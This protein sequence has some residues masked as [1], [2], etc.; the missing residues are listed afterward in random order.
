M[1]VLERSSCDDH[2][3]ISGSATPNLS[4]THHDS[5][6]DMY[7]VLSDNIQ[8]KILSSVE[9]SPF[10]SIQIDE[11]TDFS[12][13]TTLMIYIRYLNESGHIDSKF[14]SVNELKGCTSDDIFSSLM[15]VVDNKKL[16]ISKLIGF[17]SDG[18]AVMTGAKKGVSTLIKG[19]NPLTLSIHCLAH[20]LPLASEK[21]CK[22]IPYM[23][24]YLE[25]VNRLGKL[26]KFSP[27]FCRLL[28]NSKKAHDQSDA[29]KLKQVFFYQ[30]VIFQ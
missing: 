15:S 14:L 13:L 25:V 28:E 30:M 20:R 8:S 22:Q 24:K 11:G 26:C 9:Q 23:V 18:A 27:K 29:L 16:E 5:V 21:A 3:I 2:E 1:K 7:S 4:Y 17:A 12:N 10:F 19:K 6:D